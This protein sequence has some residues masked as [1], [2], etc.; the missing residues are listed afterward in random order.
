[1]SEE[2]IDGIINFIKNHKNIEFLRVTWYGGEPLLAFKKVQKITEEILKLGINYQAAMITNGYLLDKKVI[3]NLKSLQITQLQITLDGLE[4]THNIRRPHKQHKNSFQTIIKNLTDLYE[5][6]PE[7]KVALRVNVD[8]NNQDEYHQLYY[9]LKEI[10]PTNNL[11]VHPGYV[12]DIYSTKCNSSCLFQK[13]DKLEFMAQQY[14]KYKIPLAFYP[15]S[16]FGECTARHINS[17]VVGPKGEL[18][19][20]WNDIGVEDKTIGD[21]FNL[22]ASDLYIEYLVEADP[23]SLQECKECFYFPI[24]DG[25][26]PYARIES[27]HRNEQANTCA[28]IKNNLNTFLFNHYRIKNNVQNP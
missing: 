14:D 24:C 17:F 7:M 26:C 9:H 15:K 8:K 20:C 18:Y 11:S 10:I 23:L 27:V 12:T 4:Q 21:I 28:D 1:M 16:G 22:K 3:A 2:V 19:K 25:G 6:I 5:A 13:E